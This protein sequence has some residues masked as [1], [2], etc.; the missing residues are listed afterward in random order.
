MNKATKLVSNKIA[1]VFDFDQTLIPDD[2]FEVLLRDC[3]IDV[4]SFK[5]DRIKPLVAD[6]W[7]NYLARAY[8][9][10]LES[11][12]RNVNKITKAKLIELGKKIKFCDGVT[13]IFDLLH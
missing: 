13:E 1:I 6:G 2:S 3:E 10:S 8:C 4:D 11:Q 12:Q 7:D 9:L 5:S